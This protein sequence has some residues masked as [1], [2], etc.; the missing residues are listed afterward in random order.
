LEIYSFDT[1][2]STQRY[3][4]GALEEGSIT[5]PAAVISSNQ[6][7][8]I[9][10]RDNGWSGG[11]GNFF[12]SVAM[13]LPM[14][15]KDLPLASSSIY[16]AYIMKQLL[17]DLGCD[18]WLKWPNDIY[19]G[20]DKIGGV[21]TQKIGADIVCGIGINLKNS[22]N[23]YRALNCDIGAKKLLERYLERLALMPVWLS[24]FKEYR[25]E[26]ESSKGYST[27]INNNKI[28]LQNASLCEDGSLIIDGKRVYSLR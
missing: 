27:H 10:S 21:I 24:V 13:P 3:L 8:G 7:D 20:G 14:L 4:T 16:F 15:P 5:A 23:G 22:Q 26:F 12:A 11:E 6:N 2:G 25:V 18:V 1:L 9:G 28:S 17:V 19:S